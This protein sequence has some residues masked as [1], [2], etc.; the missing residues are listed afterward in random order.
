MRRM[1]KIDAGQKHNKSHSQTWTASWLSR[2]S[3]L[4][5]T[6]KIAINSNYQRITSWKITFYYMIKVKLQLDD[7]NVY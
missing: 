1:N 7:Y 6:I 2:V 5:K 3:G 4:P